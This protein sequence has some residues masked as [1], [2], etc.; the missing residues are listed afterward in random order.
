LFLALD[1]PEMA[2]DRVKTRVQEGGHHIP[3]D[4]IIRR[5]ENGLKN[6]FNRYIDVG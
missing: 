1:N 6:F 5:F 2:I 4:V 3:K